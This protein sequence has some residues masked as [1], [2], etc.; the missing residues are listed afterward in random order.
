MIRDDKKKY[1]NPTRELHLL[2]RRGGILKASFFER[3]P[4]RYALVTMQMGFGY[5][6]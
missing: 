2:E 1:Y 4:E 5:F 3:R 6:E